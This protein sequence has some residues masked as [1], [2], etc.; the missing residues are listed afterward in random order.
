MA[1]ELNLK[2]ESMKDYEKEIN[3]SFKKVVEGDILKG[4][5]ID[6]SD[7]E[8]IL[9]LGYYTDA[10]IKVAD[11]SDDP[12]FLVKEC[13]AVGEEVEAQVI[14]TDDGKGHILLS[15]KEANKV[16]AWEKLKTFMGDKTKFN[17][18][19]QGVVNAGVIAYVEGIR[20]FIP[21]S[22]LSLEYVENLEEWLAKEIQVQIITADEKNQKLILSAKEILKEQAEKDRKNKLSN[23]ES[24]LV[25]E[26]IVE[27]I[28]P[29]GAFVRLENGL[30][31]LVH[32]SQVCAKRIK[33]PGEILKEGQ[34]VTVKVIDTKDGKLSLSMKALQDVTASEIEEEV[35]EL[36]ESEEI[37]T[38]LG[39]LF[40]NIKL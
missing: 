29:Y 22:Q 19:I 39:D 34:K 21:A 26:G 30:T 32:V 5:V 9:D 36:E 37:G 14:A 38:S 11:F 1:E 31:G 10:I 20:G 6:I 8:V 12:A 33:T 28:K 25:V 27:S 40:K 23:L 18:K 17:V 35:F 24:G 13:V 4:T 7:E 3:E 16:L 2:E 15:R